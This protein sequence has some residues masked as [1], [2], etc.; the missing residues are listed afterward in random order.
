MEIICVPAI[1]A[2]VYVVIELYKK[3]LANGREKWL[4]FIP[5]LALLLG[6]ILGVAI[7]YIVPQ[8]II[9]DNVWLALVVGLCSGLSAVGGNQIFKQLEKYGITVKEVE[10]KDNADE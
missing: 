5:I 4:N 9:A 2:I 1:V 6:G 7:F 3:W 10:K 8:I